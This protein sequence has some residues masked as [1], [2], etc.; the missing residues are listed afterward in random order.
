LHHIAVG[1]QSL[2]IVISVSRYFFFTVK[3]PN[4]ASIKIKAIKLGYNPQNTTNFGNLSATIQ[5]L[6]SMA[7]IAVTSLDETN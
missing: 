2:W 4:I 7:L 1:V 5:K 6:I 3:G